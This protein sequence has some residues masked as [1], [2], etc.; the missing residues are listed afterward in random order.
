MQY[1]GKPDCLRVFEWYRR[2]TTAFK[3][4]LAALMLNKL[5]VV[6]PKLHAHDHFTYWPIIIFYCVIFGPLLF[7]HFWELNDLLG[8]GLLVLSVLV[9]ILLAAFYLFGRQWKKCLSVVAA[10]FVTG[11]VIAAQLYFGFDAKWTKFQIMRPY[12]LW[13]VQ[14]LNYASFEWPEHGVFLGGGWNET[15]IYDPSGKALTD[16]S[17]SR[18]L[19]KYAG[20]HIE[21]RDMGSNF[22]LVTSS[23]GL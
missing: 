18:S 17:V 12:Y 11:G 8:L 1:C 6:T 5:T 7:G 15:L 10:L 22:Y 19:A 21:V 14:G 16:P 3:T 23:Y 13:S 4:R 9:A 2:K 20:D